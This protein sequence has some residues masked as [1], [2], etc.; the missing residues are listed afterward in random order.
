MLVDTISSVD[1]AEAMWALSQLQAAV[2]DGRTA[3]S[4]GQYSSADLSVLQSTYAAQLA[5]INLVLFRR[6]LSVVHDWI[7][8]ISPA[9]AQGKAPESR[10]SQGE[11]EERHHALCTA[12]WD[13]LGR[14]DASA[15]E[16]GFRWWTQNR[17]KF[18]L[19][20]TKL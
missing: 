4:K 5:S 20:V 11:K 8:E 18:G 2:D 19:P 3:L 14:V 6:V 9:K 12:V 7:L 17:A 10:E 15:Q 1:D 16:E 13:A